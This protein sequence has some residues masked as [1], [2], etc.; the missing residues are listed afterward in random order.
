VEIDAMTLEARDDARNADPFA[1]F[2]FDTLLSGAARLRPESIALADRDETLT[3]AGFASRATALGHLFAEHGLKPRER[4]MLIGGASNALVIALI[5]TIRAGLEPALAPIDLSAQD[6]GAYARAVNAVALIGTT[7]YGA[8]NTGDLYFM[9]AAE[10]ASIRLVATLGPD[11]MDG[12]VDF[13]SDAIKRHSA[14]AFYTGY[15]RG[16]PSTTA[17][18]KIF[19]L[20]RGEKS[21]PVMHKQST[22]IAAGF[23]FVA[24]AKIGRDT[25]IFS[26]LPP[27]RFASLVAGPVAALLSGAA[28]HFDGPFEAKAFLKACERAGRAHLIAPALFGTDFA[29]AGV[30]R[31]LASLTLVSQMRVAGPLALPDALAAECALIDLY[32]F[33]E[34]AAVP[35]QRLGSMAQQP[36]Q[37]AHHIGFENTKILAVKGQIAASGG[38]G[39][40]GAAVTEAVALA[41]HVA[42]T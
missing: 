21:T 41:S 8:F 7:R 28:L 3:Y 5:A 18:A 19:T 40:S 38:I 2:G 27:V 6:L 35:E 39:L 9:V 33:D 13:G 32:A 15:E 16:K 29:Q 34:I 23:D 42:A 37:G 22:L 14:S 12:A 4:V 36:A 17:S 25:P 31:N 24:H 10:T 26:T 20:R 11:E 1:Q 30:T